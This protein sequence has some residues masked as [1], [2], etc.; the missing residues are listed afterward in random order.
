MAEPENDIEKNGTKEQVTQKTK[1]K[2]RTRTI[3][4]IIALIV[5]LLSLCI[6]CRADYLELFEIG[7]NY[8]EVFNQN[9]KYKVYIAVINFIFIFIATCITNS[10]IKRGLKKFF[11][12]EKQEI[13]KLPN[14]SL[15]LIFALIGAMITPNIFLEKTILFVNNSQFGIADPIFGLDIGFYMFQGPLIG[16]ILYYLLAIIIGL[17]IYTAVYYIIIFN[18]YFDGINGQTLKNN[19][20]IKHLLFNTKIITI[21]IVCIMLFNTQNVVLDNFLT[22]ND[23]LETTIVGAGVVETTIKLWGY[24]VLGVVIIVSVFMAIRFFKKNNAKNVIKSLAIVPVYLVGLFIVMVGYNTLFIN[25]SEL[26]KEKAYIT[27]NI[28]FTKTAYNI[29][30]DEIDLES[31]GTITQEEAEENKDVISNTP[32]V[33]ESVVLNNLGQTQTS[34]G[35]YTYNQAKATLYKDKLTYIS[36]REINSENTTYNSRADEYTH[37]Y[38]AVLVSANDTDENGNIVYISKDF[39]N[40]DIEEPRIYYGTETNSII[41]VSED[42]KEFDYPETTTQNATNS[43]DG[44]R[45]NIIKFLR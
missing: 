13:P 18:A 40:G 9:L 6:R 26:D 43:Y 12:E 38:G 16:L 10:F 11:E 23:E 27:T 45:R 31:T 36:A 3:I 39:E 24:R 8:V 32:V 17:T 29:N 34:T 33:T 35:Y 5:F 42:N 20:F 37:G 7:E 22:L 30:I 1:K 44:E 4:V 2:F 15:A 19:T 41:T 21:L 14:K 28:D 25:G